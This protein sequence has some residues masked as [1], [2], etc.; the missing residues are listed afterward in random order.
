MTNA[1]L[2]EVLALT[3]ALLEAGWTRFTL[4]G[5]YRDGYPVR[6]CLLGAL[7][8]ALAECLGQRLADPV[9]D[10]LCTLLLDL[11]PAGSERTGGACQL[12]HSRL[13][14][15]NDY[16]PSRRRVRALVQRAARSLT[17]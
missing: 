4:E 8:V 2:T 9:G 5:G 13:V 14:H 3:D 6:H 7:A 11:L 10:A 12:T 15:F 1:Q 17:K 16:A